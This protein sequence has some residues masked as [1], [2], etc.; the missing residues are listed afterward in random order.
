ML[1]CGLNLEYKANPVISDIRINRTA[2]LAEDYG[3]K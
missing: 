2:Q 1:S 3:F